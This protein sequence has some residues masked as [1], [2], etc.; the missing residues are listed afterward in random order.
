MCIN[1]QNWEDELEG[2]KA[3]KSASSV[4]SASIRFL[5][6]TA[7]LFKLSDKLSKDA[8][9]RIAQLELYKLQ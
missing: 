7:S 6:N 3:Q 5:E 4:K 9:G 2:V 8:M 1:L